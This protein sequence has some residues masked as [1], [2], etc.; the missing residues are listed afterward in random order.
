MTFYDI[1]I[2]G[3]SF[4]VTTLVFVMSNAIAITQYGMAE[5]PQLTTWILG[6]VG[7]YSFYRL[8]VRLVKYWIST[9]IMFIKMIIMMITI[10]LAC[11]VYLRGNKFINQDI[12]YFKS[13][14]DSYDGESL[15]EYVKNEIH[16]LMFDSFIGQFNPFKDE[17]HGTKSQNK[18]TAK[19][20]R[21]KFQKNAKK[22]MN[23]YGIEIDD[24]YL[25]YMNQQASKHDDRDFM[26]H[27]DET[28][29][30]LGIDLNDLM[31]KFSH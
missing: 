13:V 3:S 19:Q 28:L 1:F 24:S 12:P 18:K 14:I 15:G 29:N 23:D 16:N 11:T 22:V 7:I 17:N 9:F 27:L 6:L 26:D 5:Y 25:D 21:D 30:D 4:I 31:K 10:G 2:A 8:S 20:S